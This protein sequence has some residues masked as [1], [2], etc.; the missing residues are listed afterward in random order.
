MTSTVPTHRST[1]GDVPPAEPPHAPS[2]ICGYRVES[3][4]LSSL[5]DQADFPGPSYLAV[6]PG[7]RGVVLKPLDR[8]CMLENGL[9]PSIK[10]RLSRV[11]E[12][13]LGGV[14]NLYG[15]E[16]DP[17]AANPAAPAGGPAPPAWLVWEHVPGRTLAEYAA[18]AG[19]SHRKLVLA[20]RELVLMVD[21]L[22]R[23]GI[24]HGAI[25]GSN[26]IVDAYGAVRLTHVSPLLYADPAD[27]LWGVVNALRDVAGT[28]RDAGAPPAA[29]SPLGRVLSDVEAMMNPDDH[30]A[31]G[32]DAVLRVLAGRLGGIIE[33]RDPVEAGPEVGPEV[34]SAQRRRSFLGALLVVAL[35]VAVAYAAWRLG[36]FP[37]EPVPA[38]LQSLRDTWR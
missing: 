37:D 33:A 23:Q 11:R 24:V 6:G 13:A 16:R 14:A 22:H 34:D 20:A 17:A 35:G 10:E 4:L 26:V 30:A 28:R 25:R 5:A 9:H 2:E 7:G 32:G 18:D 38:W 31:P 27:D 15:V 19:C 1:E 12:L 3:A 21:G 36:R 29:E 8:D